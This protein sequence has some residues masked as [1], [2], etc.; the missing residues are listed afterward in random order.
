MNGDY[1]TITRKRGD[2]VESATMP[3]EGE[4]HPSFKHSR[5]LQEE[6]SPDA[7]FKTAVDADSTN[8]CRE[9]SIESYQRLLRSKPYIRENRPVAEEPQIPQIIDTVTTGYIPDMGWFNFCPCGRRTPA[10]A[11]E[12]TWEDILAAAKKHGLKITISSDDEPEEE[13]REP[14]KGAL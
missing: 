5:N 8:A 12:L 11:P 13:E 10:S 7:K 3:T 4:M 6:M 1:I 14:A 9:A 2:K